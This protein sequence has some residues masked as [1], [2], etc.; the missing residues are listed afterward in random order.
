MKKL[1]L[2][3]ALLV[4]AGCS[5]FGPHSSVQAEHVA[6]DEA[7]ALTLEQVGFREWIQNR[8]DLD[9]VTRE[10]VL[11]NHT[12]WLEAVEAAKGGAQ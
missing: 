5:A 2:I 11:L 9:P 8:L 3:L 7:F 6:S 4:I 10:A 1:S 12:A